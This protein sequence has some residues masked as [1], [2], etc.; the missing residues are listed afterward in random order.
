L[1]PDFA[2]AIMVIMIL[3]PSPTQVKIH[4]INLVKSNQISYP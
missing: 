2:C 3:I 4:L 1:A